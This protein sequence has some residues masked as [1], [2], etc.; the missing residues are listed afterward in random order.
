MKGE[1]NKKSTMEIN[2]NNLSN[3][4]PKERIKI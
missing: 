1:N 4:L 2:N 3:L